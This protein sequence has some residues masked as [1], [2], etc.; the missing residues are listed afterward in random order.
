MNDNEQFANKPFAEL[1][2]LAGAVA[3][4]MREAV[5]GHPGRRKYSALEDDVEAFLEAAGPKGDAAL[6]KMR[7]CFLLKDCPETQNK[8]NSPA[9]G[10][11]K[12]ISH[13]APHGDGKAQVEPSIAEDETFSLA[14]RGVRPLEG[15]GRAVSPAAPIAGAPPCAVDAAMRDVLDGKLEFAVSLTGE[16]LEGHVVGLDAVTMH[17]LR[18]GQYSPEAHLDLH[19][20]NAAQAFQ[21]LVGFFRSAWYKGLRTLLVVPGRGRNSPHGVG[22]LRDKL[23]SWLTQ[24]PF[25]RVVLGFCTAR[26]ADGGPGSV[27]V[28]LRKMRKKGEI[29]WERMPA[30]SD[31][32]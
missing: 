10:K 23:Q 31:L 20:L 22:V 7:P 21:S 3:P 25:K 13:G 27:Y 12:K 8:H 16:Y 2:G 9:R 29:C 4:G 5:G 6:K 18:A 26:P 30:D 14:M 19:G 24:E 17:K 11:K 32:Y 1:A 28:L 15:K